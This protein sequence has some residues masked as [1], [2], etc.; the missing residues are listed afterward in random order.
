MIIKKDSRVVVYL[1]TALVVVSVGIISAKINSDHNDLNK[2]IANN[3][4]HIISN[5]D[6]IA[7]LK[8]RV[9]KTKKLT[10]GNDYE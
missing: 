5:E 6:E 8:K 4:V 7:K 2:G 1:L 10:Q 9:F 3:M